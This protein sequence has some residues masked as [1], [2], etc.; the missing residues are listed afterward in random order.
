MTNEVQCLLPSNLTESDLLMCVSVVAEGGAVNPGSAA[1]ELPK[2]LRIVVKREDEAIVGVGAIKRRRPHYASGIAEKSGFPF[3]PSLH[4]LG[5]V[6]VRKD[7]QGRGFSHQI[8]AKLLSECN[9]SSLFAT[10]SHDGMKRTLAKAGFVQKGSEWQG[11]H[12]KL[13]LWIKSPESPG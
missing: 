9:E 6:A 4:E 10:T 5:Y 2:S 3:D 8:A 13:S 7:H 11:N 12:G 1:A